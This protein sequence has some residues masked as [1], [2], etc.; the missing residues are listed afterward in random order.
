[1]VNPGDVVIAI[2]TSGNSKNVLKGAEMAR[3][4]KATV[5]GFTGA[6]GGKLKDLSDLCLRVPSNDTPRIQEAHIT[7]G[8]IV[9]AIVEQAV[10]E[11]A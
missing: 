10:A 4:K 9:C 2:S 6:D 7:V 11:P 3:V 1:M 5:V 8:H